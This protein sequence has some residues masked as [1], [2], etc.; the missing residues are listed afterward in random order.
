MFN[1]PNLIGGILGY[2]TAFFDDVKIY[3]FLALGVGL[4]LLLLDIIYQIGFGYK[5]R[6]K[7]EAKHRISEMAEQEEEEEFEEDVEEEVSDL[8]FE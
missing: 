8:L 1:I 5:S 3:V 2:T 6:V 7:R 4:G